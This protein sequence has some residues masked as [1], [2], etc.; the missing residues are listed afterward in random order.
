MNG[1]IERRRESYKNEECNATS[2]AGTIRPLFSSSS[3]S[4]LCPVELARYHLFQKMVQV[5][6][7]GD[8]GRNADQWLI[9]LI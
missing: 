8:E 5:H 9:G 7:E 1:R 2:G 4:I 6:C 3:N